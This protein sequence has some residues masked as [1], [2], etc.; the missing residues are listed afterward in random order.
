VRSC[1]TERPIWLASSSSSEIWGAREEHT[2][3]T[4]QAPPARAHPAAAGF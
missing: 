4:R 3:I 1:A 2:R